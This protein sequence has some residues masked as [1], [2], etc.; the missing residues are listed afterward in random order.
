[1]S[2]RLGMA[3]GRCFTIYS[4]SRLTNDYIMDSYGIPHVDNYA[5]RQFLTQNGTA[6]LERIQNMQEAPRNPKSNHI[7]QCMTCDRPLLKIPDTY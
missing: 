3:D 1:M 4:S 5:Y 2:Q 6:A 7:N